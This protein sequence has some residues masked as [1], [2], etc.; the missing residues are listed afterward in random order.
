MGGGD[1]GQRLVRRMSELP[2]LTLSFAA[3]GIGCP[4][5]KKQRKAPC[6]GGHY[7]LANDSS[8]A[9]RMILLSR[10]MRTRDE[11]MLEEAARSPVGEVVLTQLRS[12]FLRVALAAGGTDPSLSEP[13]IVTLWRQH[14]RRTAPLRQRADTAREAAMAA[15]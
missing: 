7:G 11:T 9:V 3:H 2:L 5:G 15:S 4:A 14:C 8:L 10:L 1:Q 12:L 6:A 13:Q